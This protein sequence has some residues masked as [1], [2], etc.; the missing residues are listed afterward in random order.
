MPLYV[1]LLIIALIPFILAILIWLFGD[2]GIDKIKNPEEWKDAGSSGEQIIYITLRDKIHIPEKQILRNVYVPT[3]DGKTSEIDILVIS[4]KG[5]LIFECKN[6][7]GNIYGDMKRKKW[8]QYLGKQKNY[9]YNPFLQNK[10]HVK[11]LKKYLEQFGDLPSISFVTTISRGKWKVRNLGPNDY[12]L[13]YNCHLI[14]IY[15]AMPNSDLMQRH[16]TAIM[17]KL[18]PLSRPNEE[19]RERHI[20]N[21]K[22]R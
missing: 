14:D 8:V 10:N 16:Y 22:T 15:N 9:F 1:I 20:R 11:H 3:I 19:I 2:H 21:I 7:A 12:F 18:V 13:G 6:Y 4:R 17:N 5:L